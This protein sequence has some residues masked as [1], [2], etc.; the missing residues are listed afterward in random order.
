MI[1]M[2]S[3]YFLLL[4]LVYITPAK[5]QYYNVSHTSGT[6]P[7]GGVNVTVSANNS[8]FTYGTYCSL[9]AGS[10]YMGGSTTAL[11]YKYQFSSPVNAVRMRMAAQN[12]GEVVTFYINGTAYPLSAANISAY[13]GG[14]TFGGSLIAVSGNLEVSTNY[15]NGQIDISASRIDSFRVFHAGLYTLGGTVYDFA[16]AIDTVVSLSQYTDTI[17]CVGDTMHIPYSISNSPFLS[18]NVFTFQLSDASGSF[19]SP[20]VLGTVTGTTSGMFTYVI[21]GTLTPGNNYRVRVVS[22]NPVR[23]S[24]D[25]GKDISIGVVRPVVTNTSNNPVCSGQSINLTST[26]TVTGVS[27]KW[28][29]PSSFNSTLQNPTISSAT[30]ANSGDYIVTA[31][32]YGCIAK[33]TTSVTVIGVSNSTVTASANTPLCERDSLYLQGTVLTPG[34]SYNWSGPGGFV[35]SS[36]DTFIANTLPGMSGDYIL[37]ANYSGC[38]A[39]DTVTVLVKPQA[40]NRTISSNTPVC[41][42]KDLVLNAGS[43][44]TGVSYTWT[45]PNSF[46]NTTQ[47]PTISN[48]SSVHAGK[49]IVNYLLNGCLS[50]DSVTIVVNPSPNI[51]ISSTNTPVCADDTLYLHNTN[52]STGVSWHW[53]GP[54]GFIS[55][56]KDSFIANTT[57]AMSGDYIAAAT[58]TYGCDAKDTVTVLIKPRPAN[59]NATATTPVCAG[60]TLFLTSTTSS[61]GV[62]FSWVGPNGFTAS[63]QNPN[64]PS[65]TTNATG[66]YIVTGNLN[67]CSTK[68]TVAVVI[69]PLPATPSA[70]ANTPVCVGQDLMLG[71]GT[72]A[73]ATYQWVNT[74]GFNSTL[75]NPVITGATT[76]VAG[77]YYVRSLINGCYSPYDSVTVVVNPAPVITVYP[78]PK[79]SI[80]QGATVNFVS[81]TSN[82]GSS[83]VRTWY[84]NNN[85]IAGAANA[86]YSTSTAAD[87]DEFYLTLVAYGVCATPFTD[88]S[89]KITMNVFPWLAPSVSI[90]ANPNTTVASGT[91]INFTAT[92]VNGGNKPTY[93]W[94]RNGANIGGAISNL[95]GASTLSNNDQICVDMT[96]G[97]LC[98]NPKTVKSNCIKV[99]IESTGIKNTWAG[100]EPKIYPNPTKEILVI[101]DI[102]TGTKIQL[103]DVIGRTV[104]S[105]TANSSVA[106]INT[107]NLVPGNYILLLSTIKGE[108]LTVKITKE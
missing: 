51:F 41:A 95:W 86:N 62:G 36:K 25:N 11:G 12:A 14:C 19:A 3:L 97:Y 60:A 30:T 4:L 91:M 7:I 17:L 29:G 84:K 85:I 59:F 1:P 13:S 42:S 79:D 69:N 99:S 44:S 101:E 98:P 68:D 74:S 104:I 37:T 27:Y 38:V 50:K 56:A 8:V 6:L 57:T 108:I 34:A 83:F 102:E 40:A 72:V 63:I 58:N 35:S 94:T 43:T 32:L 45:G 65:T 23:T 73:G 64:I 48:V 20:S 92:P 81:G 55:S 15:A 70:N 5:A 93:Q 75:Q 107:Q 66:N 71:A 103:N 61:S 77:K 90:S 87:K 16:F 53:S 33:D 49:Y 2:R 9:P 78:S 88:T 39:K 52:S 54:A 24:L 22:S 47:S 80:C 31:R 106:S 76:A 26:S 105:Q 21:P 18:G 100:K 28:T 46:V 89:N 10:Y 82:A 67:G 96:S